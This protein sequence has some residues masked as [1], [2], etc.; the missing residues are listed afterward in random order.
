[1]SFKKRKGLGI[2]NLNI[3]SLLKNFDHVS[4]LVEQTT[5]DILVLGETWLGKNIDNSDV[6][7]YNYNFY[8]I[9]RLSRGGGV[10]IYVKSCLAVSIL[11]TVSLP[12]CF[13]FLAL[14]VHHGPDPLTVVGI[15]R[16]PSADSHATDT[17]VNIL[18]KFSVD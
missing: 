6:A 13:E 16:P 8:R 18:S 1:M 14:K 12:N 7:L 15:Y 4:I 17:L 10:A 11:N 2:I 3:R 9:D 5:P